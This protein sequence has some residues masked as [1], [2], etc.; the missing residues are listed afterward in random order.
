MI[1]SILTK[2]VANGISL[3]FSEKFV[4]LNIGYLLQYLVTLI[5]ACV[6]TSFCLFVITISHRS[7]LYVLLSSC[8]ARNVYFF[9]F[10]DKRNVYFLIHN[11]ENKFVFF[12]KG[13]KINT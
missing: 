2:L 13:K 8:S 11:F 9:F 6:S 5:I 12:T 4:M 7:L 3:S 1:S 10:L